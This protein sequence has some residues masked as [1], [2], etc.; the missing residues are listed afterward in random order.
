MTSKTD[1][2]LK[3]QVGLT[4]SVESIRGSLEPYLPWIEQIIGVPFAQ[5]LTLAMETNPGDIVAERLLEGL[6][7]TSSLRVR[8]QS[9]DRFLADWA[10][11]SGVSPRIQVGLQRQRQRNAAPSVV[12]DLDWQECPVALTLKGLESPVISVK[13]PGGFSS[14]RSSAVGVRALADRPPGRCGQIARAGAAG[15]GGVRAVFGNSGR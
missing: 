6:P 14:Q 5:T 11:P 2:S 12:F 1:N 7:L 8:K 15:A 4:P 10:L 3:L 13:V 9:W